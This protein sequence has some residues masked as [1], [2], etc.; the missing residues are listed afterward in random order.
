M[1]GYKLELDCKPVQHSTTHPEQKGHSPHTEIEKM[2]I[3][4]VIVPVA[5]CDRQFL[6]RL[7]LVPIKD[8]SPI[9]VVI[10]K[11]LNKFITR[12]KFKMEGAHLLRDLLRPGE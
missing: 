2:V 6:S 10:L 8:V 4:G 12:K 5:P 7:F 1:N 9:P 11:A 3:K